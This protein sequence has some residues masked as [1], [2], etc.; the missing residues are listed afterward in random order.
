VM[1]NQLWEL[2]AK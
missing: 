2:S 1:A